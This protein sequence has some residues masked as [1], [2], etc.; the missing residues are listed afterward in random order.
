MDFN[1]RYVQDAQS[2]LFG[3]LRWGSDG[4]QPACS[5]LGAEFIRLSHRFLGGTLSS[6][7]W[8]LP[9]IAIRPCLASQEDSNPVLYCFLDALQALYVE[10]VNSRCM[11]DLFKAGAERSKV[12]ICMYGRAVDVSVYIKINLDIYI[13]MCTYV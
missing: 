5:R 10:S 8:F 13:Y 7:E 11:L 2:L 9:L 1:I 4:G 12:H 3:L 6:S